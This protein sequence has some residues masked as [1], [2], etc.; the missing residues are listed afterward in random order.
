MPYEPLTLSVTQKLHAKNLYLCVRVDGE[1]ADGTPRYAYFGIF[2]DR[3]QELIQRLRTDQGL[4][5]KDFGGI[6]LARADGEPS[7]MIREFMREKFSF[8]D[9]AHH[10]TAILEIS[11]GTG[12]TR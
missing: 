2:L 5:P 1:D 10:P 6:V 3:F 4:N 8:G 9:P 12:A 11:R 7:A